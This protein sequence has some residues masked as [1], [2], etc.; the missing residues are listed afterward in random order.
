MIHQWTICY[1]LK[2]EKPAPVRSLVVECETEEEACSAIPDSVGKITTVL[3]GLPVVDWTKP[4]FN[5]GESRL[6]LD[7]AESTFGEAVG[8]GLLPRPKGKAGLWSRG[9]LD[10]FVEARMEAA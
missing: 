9:S 3:K 1:V 10:R 7:M 5:R 4:H 2:G 8:A 6:L